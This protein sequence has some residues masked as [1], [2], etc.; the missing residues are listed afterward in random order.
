MDNN[1]QM[2]LREYLEEA[3]PYLKC[4]MVGGTVEKGKEFFNRG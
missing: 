1:R 3:C 4:C 2:T